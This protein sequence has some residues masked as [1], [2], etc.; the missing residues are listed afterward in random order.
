MKYVELLFIN[1]F[2]LLPNLFIGCGPSNQV[3]Q[4]AENKK[5]AESQES[6]VCPQELIE[7]RKKLTDREMAIGSSHLFEEDDKKFKMRYT[8]LIKDCAD[9][10][11]KYQQYDKCSIIEPKHAP[12]MFDSNEECEGY[13]RRFNA[14]KL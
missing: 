3:S 6:K 10:V 14:L 7:E 11:K 5:T 1:I 4:K 13:K 12:D 8:E 2:I 9:F